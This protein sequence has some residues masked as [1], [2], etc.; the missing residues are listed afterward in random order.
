[1]D[2]NIDVKMKKGGLISDKCGSSLISALTA[3][4]ILAISIFAIGSAIHAQFAFL[5]QNRE[6]AIA[7]LSA[8]EKIEA[9]RGMAY[10]DILNLGSSF[11]SSGFAY[12]Q[13]PVGTLNVE[14]IY[15][16]SDI[17]K[18]SVNVRWLSASGR[19]MQKTIATLV[20]RNGINRQ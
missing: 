15:G 3:F 17:R 7:S 12:L 6:S 16:S 11:Q 2:K 19:T 18:V 13:N 4:A 5:N 1:M 10:N 8:Q 20:T 14:D 9:I